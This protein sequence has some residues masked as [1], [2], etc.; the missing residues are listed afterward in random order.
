MVYTVSDLR[1]ALA[2]FGEGVHVHIDG[3]PIGYVQVERRTNQA[4]VCN[5]LTEPAGMRPANAA[6]AEIPAPKP[7]PEP[8][9][10]D[11]E[12]D[13]QAEEAKADIHY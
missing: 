7:L 2:D 11:D 4:N 10:T 13:A 6:D 9:L 8:P 1:T 12:I 3:R 5:L